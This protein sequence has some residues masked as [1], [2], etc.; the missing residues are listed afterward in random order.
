MTPKGWHFQVLTGVL[1][2]TVASGFVGYVLLKRF[3]VAEL[4]EQEEE[5]EHLATVPGLG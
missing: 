5:Q 4:G 3:P 1:I 2:G